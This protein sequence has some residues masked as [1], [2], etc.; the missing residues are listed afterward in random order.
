MKKIRLTETEL[1]NII[2]RGIN[3]DQAEGIVVK[4]KLSNYITENPSLTGQFKIEN[5]QFTII[6]SEGR[7]VRV[8]TC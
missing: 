1:S 4:S 8:I 3:E 5:G 2:K 6:N 7:R